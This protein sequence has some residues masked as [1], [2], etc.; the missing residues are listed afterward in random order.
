MRQLSSL[1]F[2]IALFALFAASLSGPALAQASDAQELEAAKAADDADAD[3][4]FAELRKVQALD[5][6]GQ[7]DEAAQLASDVCQQSANPR[8][9]LNFACD[10]FINNY[11]DHPLYQRT[12]TR[13]CLRDS[14]QSCIGLYYHLAREDLPETMN[15]RK[16][17]LGIACNKLNNADGCYAAALAL[18]T[19]GLESDG[20]LA[21]R[22]Y[23]S[24]ACELGN[25]EACGSYLD[26]LRERA[27]GNYT[28]AEL[29]VAIE[30]S[31]P[32]GAKTMKYSGKLCRDAVSAADFE[33]EEEDLAIARTL[34]QRACDHRDAEGCYELAEDL[35][36]GDY[37]PK[38]PY[39]AKLTLALAC[40]MKRDEK[41]CG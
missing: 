25:V 31:C 6:A 23:Y 7:R 3:R 30:G 26:L 34:L 24:R 15:A 4:V 22:P 39:S 38:E 27:L 8:Y 5:R 35:Q 40:M 20:P 21:A 19:G 16:R 1:T 14:A 37:G 17:L 13:L 10:H 18:F 11:N 32:A 9:V 33:L 29:M 41:L 28:T 36:N 2:V 12:M